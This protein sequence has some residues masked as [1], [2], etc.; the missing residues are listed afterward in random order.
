MVI[1][2]F[3]L[4]CVLGGLEIVEPLGDKD[5]IT[6]EEVKLTCKITADTTVKFSWLM[7]DQ[8]LSLSELAETIDIKTQAV[9]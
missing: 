5:A 8:P 2:I 7:D 1:L 9:S 3:L 6:F 4:R